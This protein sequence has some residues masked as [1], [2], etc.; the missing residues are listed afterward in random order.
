MCRVDNWKDYIG[1]VLESL[2]ERLFWKKLKE[3]EVEV[4]IKLEERSLFIICVLKI[5]GFLFFVG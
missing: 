1:I 5:S 4:G 2:L 3:E